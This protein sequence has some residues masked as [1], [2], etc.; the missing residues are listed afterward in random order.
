[1]NRKLEL[2]LLSHFQSLEGKLSLLF[3][4]ISDNSA[5][6]QH[7]GS[8]KEQFTAFYNI[9]IQKI[10]KIVFLKNGTQN[11]PFEQ[12]CIFCSKLKTN[13]SQQLILHLLLFHKIK[14]SYKFTYYQ[15]EKVLHIAYFRQQPKILP[16]VFRHYKAINQNQL[17][18]F[19]FLTLFSQSNS[20]FYQK[21]TLPLEQDQ[22]ISN[23]M[24]QKQFYCGPAKN[25][26]P[27]QR[28]EEFKEL[29]SLDFEAYKQN[30]LL[31]LT[32][33]SP[34]FKG[35]PIQQFMML[36]N[37]RVLEERPQQ[38]KDFLKQFTKLQGELAICFQNHLFTL[39]CYSMIDQ[40][41]FVELSL[42]IQK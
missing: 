16:N 14:Y 17:D 40:Q 41:T 28:I 6:F 21:N 25:F 18:C 33:S 11:Q 35:S 26:K 22:Q 10:T 5:G 15:N 19:M 32:K 1:M 23:L 39:L 34:E 36:Y 24:S 12:Q 9:C 29:E 27:V 42:M 13:S 30:E 4:H 3:L 2:K 20:E 7:V 31:C 8:Q 38:L 37:T